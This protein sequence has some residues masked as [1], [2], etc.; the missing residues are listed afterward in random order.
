MLVRLRFPVAAK[1]A[2]NDQ[3]LNLALAVLRE[4][5]TEAPLREANTPETL[6]LP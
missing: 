1:H 3:A 5:P 2:E 4:L 6:L